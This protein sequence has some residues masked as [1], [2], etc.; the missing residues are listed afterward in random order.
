[1]IS[2]VC[3]SNNRETLRRILLPSLKEQTAKYE[4]ILVDNTV[5]RFKSAAAAL[6]F[7]AAQATGKYVMFVHQ[8]V[9][10]GSKT[11]L[12]E[13]EKRLD[14]ILGLG[15]AGV[16]GMS[17]QGSTYEERLRG[18]ICN[19]GQD[20]GKPV[21][22]PQAVQT[23]DEC[24]MFVPRETFQGFDEKTFDGWHCYGCD[25]ALTMNEQG[26]GAYVIPGYV[27]HRSLATNVINL[28]TYHKRLFYK[29][30]K[31]FSR[32]HATTNGLTWFSILTLPELILAI[33]INHWLFP[34]WQDA[35]K[36]ELKGCDSILD[37]GCGHNSPVQHWDV[38]YKVGVEIF[39]PYLIESQKK[40]IHNHYIEGDIRTVDF[41][42]G[43][44]DAVFSSEVLEHLTKSEGY[45]LLLNMD[46]WARKK[47]ILTTPNGEVWQDGYDSNPYQIHQSAWTVRDLELLDFKVQGMSGWKALR[48]Y[49]GQLKVKPEFLGMRVADLSQKVTKYAPSLAFQLLAIR[50]KQ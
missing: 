14:P 16:I 41:P 39:R 28:R 48:G 12:A 47:M 50:N 33:R 26:K 35:V 44:F 32:I 19:C 8:D 7:G 38:P 4:M 42:P 34:N 11:W 10:L 15:I 25:Y 9:E 18:F 6:N 23:L 49:K 13:A 22:E 40:A 27:Y 36:N 24:L 3:V 37:L 31:H 46:K 1:M 29:H 20:W 17:E 30:H 2:V 21:T 43:S 45:K 5:C